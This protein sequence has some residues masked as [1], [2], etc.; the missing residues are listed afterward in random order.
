MEI[1]PICGR[2][3]ALAPLLSALD[4]KE[5]NVCDSCFH[6][7]AEPVHLVF[8]IHNGIGWHKVD[9]GIRKSITL[10]DG[11]YV[12]LLEWID[13]QLARQRLVPR[14]PDPVTEEDAQLLHLMD[15]QR[16]TVPDPTGMP[17]RK[18][19]ERVVAWVMGWRPVWRVA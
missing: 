16:R 7:R 2:H 10:W 14:A 8:D 9:L 12:P 3:G 18:L 4:F 17:G 11:E 6:H 1:C 13:R 5:R 15:L 19:L